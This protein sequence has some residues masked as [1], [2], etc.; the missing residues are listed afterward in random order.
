LLFHADWQ[1]LRFENQMTLY[2]K[3]MVCDR[4][5]TAVQN[6]LET[7]GIAFNKI[8]LGEVEVDAISD[9]KLEHLA[10]DLASIGFELI[11]DKT[12]RTIS[13]IKSAIVDYVQ[14]N[15]HT[16][17]NF[18]KFL[19]EKLHRE[20]SGLSSL[21]SSVEGMTIES[22]L[23]L[24]K[25]EKAKELL[26]YDEMSTKE[27]ANLLGYSSAPH[28]SNQF[29]KVTGLSPGHFKKIGVQKRKSLDKV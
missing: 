26:V 27:I 13:R 11:E 21:F 22:Y 5:K 28:L 10:T 7:N 3:N 12:A 29:K 6:M 19:A 17:V 23:I 2:I 4:C 1:K 24:Q 20:Y 8:E 16:K 15:H 9:S 25:I 14:H 18:S